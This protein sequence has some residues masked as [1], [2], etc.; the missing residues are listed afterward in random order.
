MSR[1]SGGAMP[2]GDL[3]AIL[4]Y[5]LFEASVLLQLQAQVSLLQ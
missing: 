5:C 2:P 1:V 4:R 3:A